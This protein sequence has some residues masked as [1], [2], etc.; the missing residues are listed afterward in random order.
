MKD[1]NKVTELE[2]K[3]L[4]LLE[5]R[6]SDAEGHPSDFA[7][8]CFGVFDVFVWFVNQHTNHSFSASVFAC[9]LWAESSYSRHLP[10]APQARFD[11]AQAFPGVS[12]IS[13][14][15]C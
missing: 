6:V 1:L 9:Y 12:L 13:V 4:G 15:P 8:D 14:P 3:F 5:V 2:M 7:S 10:R 11:Y